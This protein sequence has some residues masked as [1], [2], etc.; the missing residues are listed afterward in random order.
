MMILDT[1]EMSLNLSGFSTPLLSQVVSIQIDSRHPLMKLANKLPWA[2]LLQI[3]FPD[4]QQTAKHQWQVGRPLNVRIHLGAYLLQQ[5]FDFTDR[6]TEQLIRDNAAYQVFCGR[7]LVDDFTVPDHTRI[8]RFRSRLSPEVQ[9]QMANVL[10]K[11]ATKLGYANPKVLD[12]DSTPQHANIAFPSKIQLLKSTVKLA[13]RISRWLVKYTHKTKEAYRIRLD[14]L[15]QLYFPYCSLRKKPSK[16]Q[17]AHTYLQQIWR[18]TAQMVMPVFKDSYLLL[19]ESIQDQLK[20]M[21]SRIRYAIETLQYRAENVLD[22]LHEIIFPEA[23]QTVYP[24]PKKIYALHAQ[25]VT[26]IHKQKVDQRKYF[27]RVFQL[28]RVAGNFL[29]AQKCESL[30]MP[31]AQSLPGMIKEHETLF[32]QDALESIATDTGYYALRNINLLKDKGVREIG[33]KRPNRKLNAPPDG[34]DELTR[35]RLY[36]RRSGIEALIGQAKH[37][38]QLERSRMKSDRTTLSAGYASVLG[39][40]LRQLNRYA[41]GSVRPSSANDAIHPMKIP[42]KI[43]N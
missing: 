11:Q 29:I 23:E 43:P 24:R 22:R 27:G 17:H 34:L 32:G 31:D 6:Q 10:T 3:I 33:L 2:E 35:Y 42:I 7:G 28:G 40:N 38:G 4:L 39:F 5:Q 15:N 16:K 19:Q 8:E 20:P 1:R 36:C 21:A 25:A 41:I 26:Y 9:R 14:W 13:Q 30:H 18:A 37:G 12:V